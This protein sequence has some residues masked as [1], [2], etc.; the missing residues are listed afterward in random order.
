MI[1]AKS[2]QEAIERLS[3]LLG[4]APFAWVIKH[5]DIDIDCPIGELG[6]D[7]M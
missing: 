6:L 3:K 1:E 2:S 4:H 7:G 5:V